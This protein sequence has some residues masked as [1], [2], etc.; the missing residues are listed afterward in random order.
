MER[1]T[2]L[3]FAPGSDTS[4]AAAVGVGKR[5]NHYREQVY[6]HIQ[7]AGETGATDRE[8]QAE[9]GM[10]GDTQRPRRWELARKRDGIGP[11]IRMNG[12]KRKGCAVWVVC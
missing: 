4:K 7:R 6:G 1:Q 12:E 10:S 5:A 11:L 8:M 9:L 3:P 2:Q